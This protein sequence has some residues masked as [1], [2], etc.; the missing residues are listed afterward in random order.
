MFDEGEGMLAFLG[1]DP[2]PRLLDED[3]GNL[4]AAEQ[5]REPPV[6]SRGHRRLLAA[7]SGLTGGSLIGG[8][9]LLLWGGWR[10]LFAGGGALAAIVAGLGLVLAAT[11]WGWVHVAEYAGLTIDARQAREREA[12]RRRWLATIDPYPRLSVSTSV[13]AGGATCVQRVLHRPVLTERH[14]F[15]FVRESEVEH[16]HGVDAPAEVIATDVERMR[17][18]ARL[19]TDRLR[20]LW[21]AASVAY[22]AAL[23]RAHDDQ[24][25]RAAHRAAALALSEHLNASLLEQPLVE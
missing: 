18:E 4:P 5:H 2:D 9:A 21:Q 6:S 11:H 23:Q 20:E 12:R 8:V 1:I 22:S 19:Q 13:A 7:G 16:V 17:R 10:L 24:E 14:T 3:L 25:Q 15:T